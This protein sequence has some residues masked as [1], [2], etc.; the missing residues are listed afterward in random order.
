MNECFRC[1]KQPAT[2]DGCADARVLTFADGQSRHPVRVGEER[3]LTGATACPDCHAS[4][5]AY[6]HPG[7]AVEACPRCGHHYR[8]CG[9][10]T[11]EKLHLTEGQDFERNA[12]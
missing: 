2:V 1:G 4:I 9:C 7:C 5:G 3:W 6:H 12:D 8:E 11:K 10:E